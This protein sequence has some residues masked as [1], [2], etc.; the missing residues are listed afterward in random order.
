MCFF[1]V[2]LHLLI[3]QI[4]LQGLANLNRSVNEDIVAVQLLPKEHWTNPSAMVVDEQNED[5][6]DDNLSEKVNTYL[7]FAPV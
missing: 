1:I 6:D 4:L 5:K 3:F 7:S 2:S